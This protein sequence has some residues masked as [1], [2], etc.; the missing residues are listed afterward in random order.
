MGYDDDECLYCYV[1]DKD[2]CEAKGKKGVC[3]RCLDRMTEEGSLSDRCRAAFENSRVCINFVCHLCG[4]RKNGG[5]EIP[6][7]R[8]HA[9]VYKE[10]ESNSDNPNSD[11]LN[12]DNRNSDNE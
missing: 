10:K 5:I 9:R 1:L 6:L 2:N 12:S 7:C 11:N 4:E 8:A 3:F